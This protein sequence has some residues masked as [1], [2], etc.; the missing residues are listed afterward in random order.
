MRPGKRDQMSDKNI[1]IVAE[2]LLECL[3]DSDWVAVD[4]RFDLADPDAGRAMYEQKHLP[5]AVF[6]DLDRDLAAPVGTDTGR[7]PLPDVDAIVAC[8]EGLGLGNAHKIV[9]Y[10]GNNGA[11]AARAWWI[12][13]WLGHDEVFLLDGGMDR[14]TALGYELESGEVTRPAAEFHAEPRHEL[15]LT[16]GE[17]AANPDLIT[18]LNLVDAR[19]TTR[20]RGE[21]EPID[22]VAGHIPGARNAP[23]GDFVYTDGTWKDIGERRRL[24]LEALGGEGPAV[25]AV[26]CGSGVTACH[27]AISAIEAG[28]PEPRVYVGSWSE[29]IRDPARPIGLGDA[30][31]A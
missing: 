6:L 18:A 7:H 24:L 30:D 4:C 2:T 3:G 1:L 29:W 25:W 28:L 31:L 8:L 27:L 21:Q 9:V 20:F 5:G 15:V 11:L 23:F 17:L 10:D 26:M 16:T 13:R 14:W 19:D 12:L 22:P